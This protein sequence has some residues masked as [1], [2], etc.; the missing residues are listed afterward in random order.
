MIKIN[1]PLLGLLTLFSGLSL[2]AQLSGTYQIPGNYP[3]VAAAINDLNTQGVSGAV[4]IN[5]NAGHTET[6]P[7]NGY[8]LTVSGTALNP[9]TFQK[10]GTGANPLIT[11][12]SG[13]TGTPGT[14]LQDGIWRLIGSDYITIDG[15][16]LLDPNTANPATMEFGF[17]LFKASATD[18]CHNNTIRNCVITLSRNNNDQGPLP[19]SDGSRGIEV[20]NAESDSHTTPVT[21]TSS[22]GSNSHNHF[23]SNTIQ[24]CNTGIALTG[25]VQPGHN[26][27]VDT[28]N[29]VGGNTI[30]TGNH[31]LNYGGGA[32]A[33]NPAAAVLTQAQYDVNVSFNRINN[34]DGNGVGHTAILRGIYLGTAMEANSTANNNTLSISS[35]TSSAQVSFIENLSG[36]GGGTN[37]ITI[38]NNLFTGCHNQNSGIIYGIRNTGS[39]P[40]SLLI[41]NNTFTN[42]SRASATGA[43]YLINNDAAVRFFITITGNQLS[44]NF[45]STVPYTG[46]VYSIYNTGTTPVSTN[47]NIS[48]NNFSG[49][50][51]ANAVG[52]GGMWFIYNDKESA[53]LTYEHN[54]FTGLNLNSSGAHYLIY[55]NAATHHSLSIS[56]NSI[57]SGYVRTA[58][59]GAFVGIHNYG[60]KLGTCTQ[61]IT[62]NSISNITSTVAGG[63]GFTGIYISGFS[64]GST[65]PFPKTIYYNNIIDNVNYNG[66]GFAIPL[67]ANYL[68]DGGSSSGS[69]VYSN[70]L[71]NF[72]YAGFSF[73]AFTAGGGVSSPNYPANIYNNV[74][75]NISSSA[76]ALLGVTVSGSG[77]GINFY[78]NKINNISGAGT[79]GQSAG[80]QAGTSTSLNV[81]NN[82]IANITCS[83][84]NTSGTNDDISG[85]IVSNSAGSIVNL[86]YN[87]VYLAAASTGTNFRSAAVSVAQTGDVTM[88]NNI[89]INNSV[90]SGTGVTVAHRRTGVNIATYLP[91]SNNNLFYAGIPSA[92]NLIFTDGVSSHQTL[93]AYQTAVAPRDGISVTENTSFIN[94]SLAGPNFLHVVPNVPSLTESGGVNIAGITDDYDGQ[95]RH[96]NPGYAG[97]GT[98]PDIGADEY[99]Q[100]LTPCT[101][102]SGGTIATTSVNRCDGDNFVF[103]TTGYTAAGGISYQWKM[104]ATAGGPYTNVTSGYGF[105]NIAFASSTL[106]IG[107]YYFV[108]EST[109][110]TNS[111]TALSNEVMASIHPIPSAS[112]SVVTPTLCEGSSLYINSSTDV[113]IN[114]HW[115]GPNSYSSSAQFPAIH[116]VPREASGTYTLV[117]S[118]AHCIAPAVS[119]TVMV[120]PSPTA[121]TVTPANASF[122][123]A[124]AQNITVNGGNTD[125]VASI[126]NQVSQ[127]GASAYP[128]PYS[129]RYGGQR[130]QTLVLA[131]DL[132]AAGF[133]PGTPLTSIEF[134]VI[135]FGA[136]WNTSVFDCQAFQVNMMHTNLTTL[137]AFQSGL[138]NVV[139][140]HNYTPSVGYSGNNVHQF[141]TPFAWNGIDNLIIETSFSN[142]STGATGGA[143]IQ[144]NS[145]S[146]A[147]ST[148]VHRMNNATPLAVASGTV[149]HATTAT[150]PD[151]R[152]NG[153]VI[154]NFAWAPATGLS[155]AT[156]TQVTATAPTS[157]VYTVTTQFGACPATETVSIEV[158]QQPTLNISVINS[159]V[160]AGNSATLSVSGAGSY[161]WS[162]GSNDPQITVSPLAT[163][164][165]TVY[166][167]NDPCPVTTETLAIQ[168]LPALSVS[169]SASPTAVCVG[170][171][172][173]LE[174]SGASSYSWTT[175]VNNSSVNVSPNQ[176]T[177][178]TVYAS[179]GPGCE[180]SSTISVISHSLP[181]V[182]VSEES[183]T[184]CAGESAAISAGGTLSYRWMPG[185]M[186]TSTVN[187]SPFSTTVYTVT[188]T[189]SYS[190]ST[191]ATITVSISACTAIEEQSVR[192]GGIRIAPNPS[193]GKFQ[194]EFNSEGEKNILVLNQLG[195]LIQSTT[196]SELTER[197]DLSG[198][199]K[200]VYYVRVSGKGLSSASFKVVIH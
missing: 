43:T 189:N 160:C 11:A 130:M 148:I 31:I 89:F 165:Y 136:S 61:T 49:Y 105:Q 78:G 27:L 167:L 159:T 177:T 162:S 10:S 115:T 63:G 186:N 22:A 156:G 67:W 185:N 75:E 194:V 109:C 200:G 108:L 178:Y 172:S 97:T 90:P 146:G 13:G 36:N 58:A 86:A 94:T 9:I 92:S 16:D 59:T 77:A 195:A 23:Y 102:I 93:G 15:I 44:Y 104:S 157:Q 83:A 69:A 134:A 124:A 14:A 25:F 190:C 144:Y 7:V 199:A 48:S 117:I 52:T 55:N 187:V 133:V 62:A 70:T 153:S 145:P 127:N 51:F 113:G 33:T 57:V 91:V 3:T 50:N 125:L 106:G 26:S 2:R 174:A 147:G 196:T 111:S 17:G 53:S 8:S 1:T 110:A 141:T 46:A 66:S 140:P 142:A 120:M 45:N 168:V 100:N 73:G 128:A 30:Q 74:V 198:F 176:N 35:G 114:Y 164:I 119:G 24:N 76:G 101:S 103:N 152:L 72:H 118:S 158:A 180:T 68:G 138:A 96:G 88:Q 192:A 197:F 170:N 64:V 71:S 135:S 149:I 18:G 183:V 163:T 112:L 181:V 155:A 85:I 82:M 171:S 39:T 188:G 98:A 21:V 191:R 47:I 84:C 169:V 121:L 38:N 193:A 154:N 107:N 132:Q 95:I 166:G 179:N 126:G 129:V 79:A 19:S 150:R 123:T 173:T 182:S 175:G 60:P 37:T 65:S 32:G 12:Y 116:N 87:T 131:S 4:T 184:I 161:T 81:Y 56:H 29:D 99:D 28:G 122:C 5:I 34:N 40:H 54:T 6:A 80:L 42:T 20:V 143:V 137:T 41:N 139:A 151:L